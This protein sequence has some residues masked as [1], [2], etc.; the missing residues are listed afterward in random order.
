M[1]EGQVIAEVPVAAHVGVR[2]D[3]EAGTCPVL[4][5]SGLVVF[6]CC[7]TFGENQVH[8]W[9]WKERGRPEGGYEGGRGW[10]LCLEGLS[11]LLFVR[12]WVGA[13]H[14]GVASGIPGR[15]L[16]A[17]LSRKGRVSRRGSLLTIHY[18]PDSFLAPLAD[19]TSLPSGCPVQG[20]RR[21][22]P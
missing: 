12:R 18:E 2:D 14:G 10:M 22:F 11:R 17:G 3:G 4:G 15:T 21:H 20:Q 6:I 5:D 9:S 16:G 13:G 1:C 19:F 7:A 8:I